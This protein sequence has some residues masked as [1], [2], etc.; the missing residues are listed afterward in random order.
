MLPR[1][2]THEGT[3]A[4]GREPYE[5]YARNTRSRHVEAR[6][7]AAAPSAAGR[8]Q[9]ALQLGE[10]GLELPEMEG[11]GLVLL[12]PGHLHRIPRP[13]VDGDALETASFCRLFESVG[14]SGGGGE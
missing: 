13:S 6:A 7:A 5:A 2:P 11:R 12:C 9:L 10:L 8:E 3:L 14:S 1:Q 4:D